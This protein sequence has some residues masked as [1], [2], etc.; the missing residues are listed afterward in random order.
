MEMPKQTDTRFL[1]TVLRREQKVLG[2]EFYSTVGKDP[3]RYLKQ[4]LENP[5]PDERAAVPG[6]GFL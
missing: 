6:D 2:E 3:K 5:L 4:G 1:R